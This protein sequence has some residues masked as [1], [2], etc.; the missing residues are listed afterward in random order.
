M[1]H[2]N[3]TWSF[4]YR[5]L[6]SALR[7]DHRVIVPDHIGMGLS[8][9]PDES[10]YEYT[11]DRRV[12]DLETLLD[13]LQLPQPLTLVLHDW[14]GMI[15]M[16]LATRRPDRIAR[17]VVLNT[18]AFSLPRSKKMPWQLSLA[19]STILGSLLVRGFNAFSSG[20]VHKCVTRRPL[21]ADVARAYLAPYDSWRNRLAV[22]RFI[23]D[24]P[25][26]PGDRA[27]ATVA[28]VEKNIATF[29]HL[30]VLI[31]WGM[32][33]FVFDVHFLNRWLELFPAAFVHRF[34]DAGHYVLEDAHEQ[35]IPLV[36]SFLAAHPLAC[37]VSAKQ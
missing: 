35:I 1:L 16:A 5:R 2:G 33:D 25:L 37:E 27:Y 15:G 11:L 21:S 7:R 29:Q 3:P 18:G 36:Q 32:K 17:L 8:S 26:H 28:E 23:Q 20:A 14:G 34:V 13:S 10:R 6:V 4:Y 9:K 24:I 22:H 31:C 12:A 30:P 19:R